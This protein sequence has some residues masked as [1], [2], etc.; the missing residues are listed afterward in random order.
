MLTMYKKHERLPELSLDNSTSSADVD[1]RRN[2]R[3]INL[4]LSFAPERAKKQ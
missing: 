4:F 1:I 3:S 2:G